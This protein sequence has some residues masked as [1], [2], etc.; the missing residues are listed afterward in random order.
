MDIL[1]F[2]FHFCQIY[3]VL[4]MDILP[5]FSFLSN[6]FCAWHGY[7]VFVFIFVKFILCL[8]W[9]YC[10]CFHFNQIFLCLAW[11]Y[12]LCFHLFCAWHGYTV[13]VFIFV[14]FIL[15]LTWIY[16]LCFHFCHIYFVLGMDILSL[17]SFFFSILFCAWH[18]YTVFV[19]IFVKFILC[20]TWTYCPCFHFCQIYF[21]PGMD[22]LSLFSFLSNLFCA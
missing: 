21:V 10:L 11:I 19:F 14:T 6:L 12:C 5:L 15:C 9:I 3:F 1:Y 4:D 20:L 13:F 18:G 22:I 17:F 8:A 2:C 7:T 16:C